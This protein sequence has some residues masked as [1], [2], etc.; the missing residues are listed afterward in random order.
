MNECQKECETVKLLGELEKLGAAI[1]ETI[2]ELRGRLEFVLDKTPRVAGDQCEPERQQPKTQLLGSL[3][4]LVRTYR[5]KHGEL[6][7]LRDDITF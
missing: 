1:G 3:D 6:I 7:D 2:V 4:L 5:E